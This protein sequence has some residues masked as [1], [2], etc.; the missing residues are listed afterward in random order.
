MSDDDQRRLLA[1]LEG[2]RE[3]LD[4]IEAAMLRRT[5]LHPSIRKPA[6]F[7]DV[8]GEFEEWEAAQAGEHR[9]DKP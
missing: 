2:I 8:L 5:D 3:Q 6:D 7:A 1:I 4:R 9:E